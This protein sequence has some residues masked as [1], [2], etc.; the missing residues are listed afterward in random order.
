MRGKATDS[1]GK[2]VADVVVG[3]TSPTDPSVEPVMTKTGAKGTYRLTLA[4]GVYAASCVSELGDCAAVPA[5]GGDPGE[6]TIGT[7]PIEVDLAV[8]G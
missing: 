6:L 1:E 5:D 3:F 8:Q 4:P 7:S 2:P